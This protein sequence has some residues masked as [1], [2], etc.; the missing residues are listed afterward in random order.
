MVRVA[1]WCFA[2]LTASGL[3]RGAPSGDA[4]YYVGWQGVTR[5]YMVHTPVGGAH[6]RTLPVVLVLHGA[7][8]NGAGIV[9]QGHWAELA[10]ADGFLVVAP[11]AETA[12]L[13][14]AP[15]FYT[16]P[17]AWN[18]GSGRG[19]WAS[20]DVDDVGF[21]GHVLDD[22]ARRYA[23][24]RTRIY[25][26]GFSSGASMAWRLGV[27]MADRVAAIA[28]VSGYLWLDP[29]SLARPVPALVIGGTADPLNPLGGGEA[30]LLWGGTAIKPPVLSSPTKWARLL[31][32]KATPPQNVKERGL[33]IRVYSGCAAELWVE[34]VDGLGH[35]WPGGV[36]PLPDKLVGASSS[37]LDATREIWDFFARHTLGGGGNRAP[38]AS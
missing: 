12:D 21:I 15:R 33:D 9:R 27:E 32:C 30:P 29:P 28:P 8:G 10:D 11:D 17:T 16:N 19:P 37:R 3:I 20:R 2:A 22:V 5:H 26:T 18:D 35:R 38:S 24:D 1:T 25:V 14:R 34:L 7:S 4:D 36:D 13:Q 6:G 31:R 23:I